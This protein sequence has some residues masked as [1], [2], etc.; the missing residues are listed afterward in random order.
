MHIKKRQS[1][2][3]EYLAQNCGSHELNS[4]IIQIATACKI[5]SGRIRRA[6]FEHLYGD[7]EITNFH[8]EAVQTL[9]VI[10]NH[11]FIESLS[12]NPHVHT[13][14]SEEAFEPIRIHETGRYMIAYDPLDGSS[15]INANVSIGSIFGISE[16]VDDVLFSGNQMI[17]AGYALYS[18][19]T[20]FVFAINSK[21]QGFTLDEQ[22]GEFMLT[23]PDITIPK[24]KKMYS[25]NEA[26]YNFWTE[27][28]QELIDKFK[29]QDYV[30]RYIGS[31]V[32][33]IHRTLLYGG[34]FMNIGSKAN[35]EGKLRYMY[36]VGPMSYLT[37][38]AGG[39]AYI[40]NQRALDHK[41]N[42]IH[43]RTPI[44]LG[45]VECVQLAL[46]HHF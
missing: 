13:L 41:P 24:M 15:N 6:S 3:F 16:S 26:Y 37:E 40:V 39:E 38:K 34:I 12:K 14:I 44:Y 23:H 22:S 19:S 35:P 42:N 46:S 28:Q 18:S 5:I 25:I 8:G 1:T 4:V 32:A 9:D 11:Q 20:M 30:S 17:C 2:L 21:P 27:G 29:D 10:A 7:A 33:D 43:Q 36:E 31:M 45:S